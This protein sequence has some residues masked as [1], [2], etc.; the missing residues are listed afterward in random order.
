M[1]AQY[2][3]LLM[4]D[5]TTR[6]SPQSCAYG[7]I[8]APRAVLAREA[9]RSGPMCLPAALPQG[10]RAYRVARPRGGRRLR[11]DARRAC[12]LL[13]AC[14][15]DSASFPPEHFWLPWCWRAA[16]RSVHSSWSRS[17]R[18]AFELG[19]APATPHPGAR[20]RDRPYSGVEHQGSVGPAVQADADC[21]GQQVL[22]AAVH[23]LPHVLP[24]RSGAIAHAET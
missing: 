3:S 10:L 4:T 23:P 19:D 18:L 9:T 22:C 7:E 13:R 16:S 5:A 17:R 11:E 6:A 20:R 14:S 2:R 24:K 8:G 15:G 1:T 12:S 21:E